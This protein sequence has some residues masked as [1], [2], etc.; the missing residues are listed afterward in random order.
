MKRFAI[1]TFL[2]SFSIYIPLFLGNIFLHQIQINA[3]R[4]IN[5]GSLSTVNNRKAKFEV[6]K[7]GYKPIYY[8]K[9]TKKY[10]YNSGLIYPIGTLPYTK[11]YFCDEGYGLIKFKS[12]RFGLR[13]NDDKWK[14]IKNSSNIFFIGD[15]FVQGACVEDYSTLPM[16]TQKK[17]NINTLNL[18]TGGNSPYE[19]R[20]ILKNLIKPII[21]ISDTDNFVIIVFYENDNRKINYYD[22]ELLET[23]N[24]IIKS[25]YEREILPTDEYS[26]ELI[27]L[28][29]DNFALSE[30]DIRYEIFK[31]SPMYIYF[32]LYQ[33]RTRLIKIFKPEYNP[34]ISPTDQ[35]NSPTIKAIES[36]KEICKISCKPYISYIPNSSFWSPDSY[37]QSTNIYKKNQKEYKLILKEAAEINGIEFIN[38]EEVIDPNNLSDYS[39]GGGH[40]SRDGYKKLSNLIADKIKKDHFPSRNLPAEAEIRFD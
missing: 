5:P 30:R 23:S 2:F 15:S 14:N 11:T 12:D 37:F 4:K 26:E 9:D 17:I 21:E 31:R 22:E 8:P 6:S 34:S 27:K 28:L 10:A 38:G 3:Q 7:R 33:I 32:S 13:N 29:S 36:L 1:N 40:L 35:N 19:Y 18:G 24:M 16:L 39:P 25:T 20:A